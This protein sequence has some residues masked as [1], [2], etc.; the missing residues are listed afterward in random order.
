MSPIALPTVRRPTGLRGAHVLAAFLLFF[1]IVFAVNG[2]LIYS[3]LRTHTGLVANEPYRKGLQYNERIA[4]SERQ[5]LLNWTDTISLTRQGVVTVRISATEGRPVP[6]LLVRAVVGRPVTNRGDHT[7]DLAEAAPGVYQG[8]LG[9]LDAGS[10]LVTVEARLD[11]GASEPL[12]RAR[13]RLWLT[14]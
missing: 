9:G 3:A 1:G 7:L 13:R 6:S 4:A 12:Y 10:W 5:A 2:S 8:A 11:A 14:P